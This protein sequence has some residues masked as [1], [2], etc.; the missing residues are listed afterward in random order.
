[1]SPQHSIE[2]TRVINATPPDIYAA[3]TDP[4]KMERWLG[5]VSADV[6]LG[7]GYRFDS[8]APGGKT[9]VYTGK[10][11]VLE[12]GWRV[13]Q[14]FLAGEPSQIETNPYANEFIEVR[15]RE[16][17]SSQTELTFINGWDGDPLSDDGIIAVRGAWTEWLQRMEQSLV[18]Q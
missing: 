7:G 17:S 16:L 6:R 14:S 3:W 2:I 8:P 18:E 9:Y 5:Q 11:L 13:V 4:Q 12:D 10:Y 1:M 15:L